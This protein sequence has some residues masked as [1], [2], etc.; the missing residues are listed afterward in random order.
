MQA[1]GAPCRKILRKK[2]TA[3]KNRLLSLILLLLSLPSLVRRAMVP[4]SSRR[5]HPCSLTLPSDNGQLCINPRGA[6]AREKI[7]RI[8]I[9]RLNSKLP[10]INLGYKS[11]NGIDIMPP[12]VFHSC[13]EDKFHCMRQSVF[14]NTRI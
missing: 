12:F 4:S 9:A 7:A 2:L 8:S 11:R 10:S 13:N 3:R 1:D 6:F 5:L 14:L